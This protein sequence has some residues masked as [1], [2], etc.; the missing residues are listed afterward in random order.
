MSARQTLILVSTAALLMGCA[1]AQENPN[2]Q[3]SSKYNPQGAPTQMAQ[4]DIEVA[5]TVAATQMASSPMMSSQSEPVIYATTT[6]APYTAPQ[7]YPIVSETEQAFDAATMDGTP[8]Y[9]AMMAQQ[10]EE[11]VP[12]IA[13]AMPMA[14]QILHPQSVATEAPAI[15]AAIPSGPQPVIYDYAQ[16]VVMADPTLASTPIE[17]A[18]PTAITGTA[19]IVQDKDTVY[20]LARSRC[21][22]LDAITSANGIGADFAIK[23]GQTIQLPESRC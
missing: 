5:N 1:T 20:S 22:G 10:E 18:A 3:F 2:Y 17:M 4:S 8:G 21:V 14:P 19:Y 11:A 9:A 23:I 6:P 15:Q 7:T 13:P 12:A 16:N